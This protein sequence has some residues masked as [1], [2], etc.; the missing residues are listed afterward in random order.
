MS[1][2]IVDYRCMQ[3]TT[4]SDEPA[5]QH[6]TP[7]GLLTPDQLASQLGVTVRTLQ[8]W[9]VERTGPPRTVIGKQV[10]YRTVSVLAWVE[11][12]EQRRSRT[13]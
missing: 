10:F 1:A 4:Q 3:P 6:S 2:C 13:R 12:C 8:R 11:S 9:E 5:V 7:L